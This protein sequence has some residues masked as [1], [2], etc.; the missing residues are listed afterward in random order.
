MNFMLEFSVGLVSVC[1]SPNLRR[2]STMSTQA[3]TH[4]S[5]ASATPRW[6]SKTNINPRIEL[7]E[8]TR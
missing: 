6:W 5:A 3:K 2:F 4:A 1:L 8:T 7:N